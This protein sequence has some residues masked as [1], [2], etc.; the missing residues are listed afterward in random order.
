MSN[1]RSNEIW[2]DD[3][4]FETFENRA[5]RFRDDMR[6]LFYQYLG[7]TPHSAVLDGGCGT[8]VFTRYLAKG[9]ETGTITGFDINPKAIGYGTEQIKVHGLQGRMQ[10]ECADGFALP[11]AD[12]AYDAVTNYTYLGVLSD[13]EAGLRELIRVCKP[14]G[15][16]SCVVAGKGLPYAGW[17][18]NYSFEG[19]EALQRLMAQETAIFNRHVVPQLGKAMHQD[20]QWPGQRYPKLLAQCG[21]KDIHLYPYGYA[22]CF[23]DSQYDAAYRTRLLLD[24]TADEKRWRSSRYQDWQEIYHR[25]GFSASDAA[26][27]DLLLQRKL[28]YLCA[29]PENADSY[30]WTGGFN[31]IVAGTKPHSS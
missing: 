5:F 9:L 13:G 8:G 1:H 14:G 2:R 4:D 23:S 15:T 12:A 10:L 28:D 16:V 25:E 19:A 31:F 30:E 11:Y 6:P 21:L 29:H 27:L 26:Q 17:P 7:I 18:G 3:P 24:A 20:A 22:L